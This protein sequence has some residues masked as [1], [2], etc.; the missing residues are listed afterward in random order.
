MFLDEIGELTLGLQVK[1]LRV[2]Q[3]RVVTPVGDTREIA[4]DVRVVAAT[5]QNLRDAVQQGRFRADLYYRLNV[6]EVRMPALRERR[7][8]IMPLAEHFLA[9]F[10]QRI[11][12]ELQGFDTE[13]TAILLSLP[14]NGNVR[15]LENIVERAVALETGTCVSPAYLPDPGSSVCSVCRTTAAIRLMICL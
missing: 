7:E 13:A 14:F 10:N 9:A 8:D 11:G 12:R 5:H 4:V 2:L 3:E 1:L 6:I 15:E